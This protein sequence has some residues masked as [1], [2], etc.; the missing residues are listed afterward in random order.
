M[1]SDLKLTYIGK[2]DGFNIYEL[3]QP[4]EFNGI[5]V[6]IG[7]KTNLTSVPYPLSKIIKRN[8]LKYV[9]SSIIHDY[10]YECKI[11]RSVADEIF[12]DCMIEEET[13]LRY[14]VPFYILVRSFG[15]LYY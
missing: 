14:R 13:P 5:K 6:P 10:L 9:R 11:K 8:N 3:K 4:L 12:Y 7:F 15:W 2:K 1:L